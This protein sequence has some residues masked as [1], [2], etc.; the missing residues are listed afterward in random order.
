VFW[1]Q[2]NSKVFA[3]PDFFKSNILGHNRHVA[4]C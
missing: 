2:I 4:F 1:I 3:M